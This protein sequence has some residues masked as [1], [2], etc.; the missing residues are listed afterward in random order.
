ME[1]MVKFFML[2]EYR[3]NLQQTFVGLRKIF[4]AVTPVCAFGCGVVPESVPKI[5][6]SGHGFHAFRV[7][8][9]EFLEI[10]KDLSQVGYERI[11]FGCVEPDPGKGGEVFQ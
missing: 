2:F 3:R 7:Q 4:R 9:S 6:S 5:G 10:G 1:A 11:F 8:G